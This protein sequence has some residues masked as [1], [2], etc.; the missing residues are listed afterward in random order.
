MNIYHAGNYCSCRQHR[1]RQKLTQYAVMRPCYRI[2]QV[3][4]ATMMHAVIAFRFSQRTAV[5]M[6]MK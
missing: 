2:G 3:T 5:L 1:Q 6:H 4:M